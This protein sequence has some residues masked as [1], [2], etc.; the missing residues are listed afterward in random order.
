MFKPTS[1]NSLKLVWT[2]EK[3]DTKLTCD[4]YALNLWLYALSLG[5]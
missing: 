3:K 5:S 4:S 2:K 1:P